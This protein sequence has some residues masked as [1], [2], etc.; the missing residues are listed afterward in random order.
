MLGLRQA[1]K[2]GVP[3]TQPDSQ[4]TTTT[5]TTT[6]ATTTTTTTPTASFLFLFRLLPL[7]PQLCSVKA[8]MEQDA[9]HNHRGGQKGSLLQRGRGVGA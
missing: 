7:P 2:Q 8:W 4:T 9:A 6:T 5:T 3:D 1:G